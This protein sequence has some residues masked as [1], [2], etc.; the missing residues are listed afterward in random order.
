MRTIAHI[1]DL[2]FGAAD[3]PVAEGLLEDLT[4]LAPALVVV[5]GDLTQRARRRQF[6]AARDFLA[7][8]PFPLLLVPGNH[9]I[10]LYDVARRFL[11]PLN[12]Y[13]RY[14]TSDLMPLFRDEELAVLGI[15]TARSATW[16]N[17]R[18][19]LAQIQDIRRVFCSV[20][21]QLFKVMVTHHP[22]VPPPNDPSPA[23]VGRGPLALEALQACGVELLLAG[24]LHIGYS[25]DVTA[26]YLAMRRSILVAQAGTAISLRRRGEANAYNLIRIDLPHLQ[27]TVRGW[28]GE[29]FG[30]V[31]RTDYVKRGSQWVAPQNEPDE[32]VQ[33]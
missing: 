4:A 31:L 12:R 2:H 29:K 14:I 20:P 7:R 5:S 13:Q 11:R 21:A 8:I 15:N 17:G 33:L 32:V 10:P 16:K 28:N 23:L 24:H 25:G 26:Q 18:I 3:L 27:I 19:S 30:D 1:S 6:A 9:D 22:F